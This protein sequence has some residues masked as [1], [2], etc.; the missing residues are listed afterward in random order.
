M[1]Y[2]D[3][4]PERRNLIV[5]SLGII[6][7]YLA[8]GQMIDDEVKFKLINIEFKDIDILVCFVWGMLFWFLFRYVVTNKNSHG[9]LL[10]DEQ[11]LIN[12]SYQFV[13]K[14]AKKSNATTNLKFS[15]IRIIYNNASWFMCNSRNTHGTALTGMKGYLIRTFYMMKII[16]KHR[17]TTDYYVPYLLFLCAVFLGAKDIL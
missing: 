16:F 15:K 3:S 12:M 8:E 17:A 2:S 10:A 4:N 9:K 6:I 11:V 13:L 5:L 1:P 14:Y 7:F